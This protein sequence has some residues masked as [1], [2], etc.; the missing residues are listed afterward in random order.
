MIFEA[1]IAVNKSRCLR[2]S[3]LFGQER[4]LDKVH[5]EP[6]CFV[7]DVAIL[8]V[9]GFKSRFFGVHAKHGFGALKWIKWSQEAD[10]QSTFRKSLN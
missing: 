9:F 3:P 2:V 8:A 10:S 1:M 5:S 7:R 4:G 6:A